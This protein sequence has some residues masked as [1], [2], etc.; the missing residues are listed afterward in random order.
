MEATKKSCR[1]CPSSADLWDQFQQ[2]TTQMLNAP[3][4]SP[5][6]ASYEPLPCPPDSGELGRSTWTY[7]HS[8]AAYYPDH[9]TT[10]EKTDIRSLLGSF[11][12]TYP[13]KWCVSHM[14]PYMKDKPPAVESRTTL[15]RWMCDMHNEVNGRLGKPE[16]D[17][18]KV[19][20]RW[21]TGCADD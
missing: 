8:L 5:S 15:S 2:Q 18:D 21:L 3:V 7:L 10:E 17:C 12:R 16:F 13:C 14:L 19:D 4:S 6:V 20:E 11:S 9:P 1:A